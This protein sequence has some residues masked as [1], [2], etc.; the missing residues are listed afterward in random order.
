MM[1]AGG[2]PG[3]AEHYWHCSNVGMDTATVT[4]ASTDDCVCEYCVYGV[5]VSMTS[6]CMCVCVCVSY[7][8]GTS[9]VS[10]GNCMCSR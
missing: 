6:E 2:G 4:T 10:A 5:S 3:V 8:A 9:A 7:H 1:R